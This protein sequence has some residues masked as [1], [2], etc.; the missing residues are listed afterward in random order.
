MD[1]LICGDVGF[2]QDR[3]GAAGG[4]RRGHERQAGG[5]RRAD[6]AAGPPALQDLL[7][8]LR[9]LAGE[10]APALP[11]GAPPRKPLRR[12]KSGDGRGGD[13][14][15]HPRHLVEAGEV[16]G[17]RPRHRRRGAALRRQAQGAAE[18]AAGRRAHADP[19]G[20][21]DPAHPADGAHRHPRDVDHRHPAGRPPGG[22]DLRHALRSGDHPR[23]AAAREVPR[24]AGL[25]RGAAPHRPARDREVP[26]RAGARG[27]VHRR[28][29][30][31]GAHP[32][33]GGD[34]R[35]LRR[36]LRRAALHHHRGVRAGRAH[37]QHPDRAPGGHVRPVAALPDPRPGRPG[38]GA[39]LRLP[40]HA[41]GEAA[42]AGGREATEGAAV[43][44]QPGRRLPARQS[45]PGHPRRRQ[46]AG[47]RAVRPHQGG[48]RRA[49]PADAGGRG[50]PSCA[51]PAAPRSWWP[52]AAGRP[53]STP[54]R[55]C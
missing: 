12:A 18:G 50:Q 55:R 23:G 35:L 42:D 3:G 44:G 32:A 24:R 16:Q 47:R 25:L 22:A 1:R 40:D 10:G 2:R 31:D 41:G 51:P 49:L 6:D 19:D 54:A 11:H 13:R 37:R 52:A 43:A 48:G 38:Q 53:R 27:E 30:P 14:G 7:R 15:R 17:P 33:G 4:L 29:R 46:P 9:R 28:P 36:A 39:G 45:R 20:H 26:A 8:A 5:H 21:A 34:E